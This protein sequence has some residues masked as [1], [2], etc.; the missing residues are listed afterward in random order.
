MVALVW[1]T[2]TALNL[3]FCAVIFLLGLYVYF[4]HENLL[5]LIIALA[6]GLFGISHAVGLTDLSAS[7]EFP[8][9]V[10]RTTAYV[11]VVVALVNEMFG[12]RMV[13]EPTA[14]KAASKA[15]AKKKKTRRKKK[16]K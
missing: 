14:V 10:V 11:I 2:I 4:K 15:L 16:K 1:S 7:M 6:F 8:L 12:C 13:C 9:I 5:A 3:L